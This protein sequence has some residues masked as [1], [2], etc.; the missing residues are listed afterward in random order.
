MSIVT[1][2]TKQVIIGAYEALSSCMK[3]YLSNSAQNQEEDESHEE[4]M[5]NIIRNMRKLKHNPDDD[6]AR[7]LLIQQSECYRHTLNQ[8]LLFYNP[9]KFVRFA[10][11][12]WCIETTNK[13]DEEIAFDGID[14]LSDFTTEMGLSNS[15]SDMG[16][17]DDSILRKVA[18]T[19]IITPG[20]AKQLT[21]DE[22]YAILLESK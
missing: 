19:T 20:C 12:V 15:L 1:G 22:I 11:E 14:A 6:I 4:T 9:E 7:S 8:N 5:R 17:T 10:K 2:N 16:I 21:P 18:D 13:T 3:D